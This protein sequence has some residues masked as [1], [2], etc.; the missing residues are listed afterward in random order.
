[1]VAKYIF[2][3]LSFLNLMSLYNFQEPKTLIINGLIVTGKENESSF[4]GHIIIS[5]TG[6]ILDVIRETGTELNKLKS[7]YKDLEI[8]NAEDNIVIPGGVDAGVKF[9]YLEGK[10]FIESSDNFFTGSVAA[11]VGG[12]TTIV[13]LIEANLNEREKNINALKNKL[14]EGQN[15]VIDYTFHFKLNYLDD[16]LTNRDM[17]ETNCRKII[18]QFGLNTFNFDTYS[19]KYELTKDQMIDALKII[20]KYGGL[21]TINCLDEKYILNE[22]SKYNENEANNILED[23]AKFK[24]F[25]EAFS[26]FQEKKAINDIIT[27]GKEIGFEQGI[28]INHISTEGALFL[29]H[30]T[31]K[32]GFI[33]TTE[34]TPQHL[35]LTEDL[36]KSKDAIDFITYPPLRTKNDIEH[37]WQGLSEGIIDFIVS[38]HCPF[39]KDQKRGKRTKPD[40]RIFYNEDLTLN[41][42][43]DDTYE[44]WSKKNPSIFDVPQGLP[45]VETR[46]ILIYHFGV[47][48]KKISLEK[49]VEVIST[50]A[51]KRFGLYPKKGILG[52]WSDADIVI[53][54]PNEQTKL[55]AENLHQN[56]DFCPYE[57]MIVNGKIKYVFSRGTKMVEDYK[58]TKECLTHQGNMLRR[59]RYFIGGE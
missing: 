14:E 26:P 20:K 18:H 36:Y 52:K 44:K 46:L 45:G 7:Q 33:A 24:A 55:K 25:I 1:M 21:A 29:I 51:A 4:K 15:S 58:I 50:N 32:N 42:T 16:V 59:M 11:A 12:T 2:L 27:L 34:V 57:D 13:D 54:D 31:K 39:T 3:I 38:D 41:K 43:Y 37:L 19:S 5:N 10:H 6:K 30:E 28:H 9:D 40:F 35:I 17:I 23:K 56:T 48:E 47:V 53:I 49:F 8:I 22:I